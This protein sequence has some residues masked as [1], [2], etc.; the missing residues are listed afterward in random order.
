M[1]KYSLAKDLNNYMTQNSFYAM[2]AAYETIFQAIWSSWFPWVRQF[3]QAGF[4]ESDDA[5]DGND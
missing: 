4:P 2:R 1:I 5:L 3:G